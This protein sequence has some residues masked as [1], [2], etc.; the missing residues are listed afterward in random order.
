[1]IQ[2]K[3]QTN[4]SMILQKPGHEYRYPIDY[5]ITSQLAREN[6]V[7]FLINLGESLECLHFFRL[8]DPPPDRP[9]WTLSWQ[10]MS[11]FSLEDIT[12]PLPRE[13][14]LIKF[15]RRWRCEDKVLQPSPLKQDLTRHGVLHLKGFR[16]GTVSSRSFPQIRDSSE[17]E[18]FLEHD[19]IV[20]DGNGDMQYGLE[21]LTRSGDLVYRYVDVEGPKPVVDWNHKN[22]LAGI[23]GWRYPE[24]DFAA[25]LICTFTVRSG[26]QVV[27][28]SGSTVAFI[29]RK[30][31]AETSSY[32]LIG[33]AASWVWV[34]NK[35]KPWES[36]KRSFWLLRRIDWVIPSIHECSHLVDSASSHLLH[37]ATLRISCEYSSPDTE[38]LRNQFEGSF[39]GRSWKVRDMAEQIAQLSSEGK[40][41]EA[42]HLMEGEVE[43]FVL[44]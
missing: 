26:D 35:L 5:S 29:L 37:P 9:S 32:Q 7:K 24:V 12:V 11:N 3:T 30:T 16:L 15:S 19:N 27:M 38:R 8:V 2:Y 14:T 39:L 4:P 17:D 21:R 42:E 43:D 25:G 10:E 34:G 20:A 31:S 36:A 23:T 1:M 6:L 40:H 41:R 13:A 44:V 33:S 22:G 28:F 18:L